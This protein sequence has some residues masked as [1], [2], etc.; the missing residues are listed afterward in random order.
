MVTLSGAL[1]VVSVSTTEVTTYLWNQSN[2]ADVWP[3]GVQYT[4]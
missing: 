4:G 2:V 1:P 3:Y